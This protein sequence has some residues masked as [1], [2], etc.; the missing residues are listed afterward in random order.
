MKFT[1]KIL[2]AKLVLSNKE[3]QGISYVDVGKL[4][5]EKLQT[6]FSEDKFF[7]IKARER[8][9]EIF[10]RSRITHE[11][12]G[13]YLALK[14][15]GILFEPELKMNFIEFI[16][17]NTRDSVLILKWPGEIEANRIYFL[18]KANG[19]PVGLENINYRIV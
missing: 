13:S 3:L 6:E 11:S 17:S 18:S 1:D 9:V 15:L 16:L 4:F 5:S 7:A 12:L 10:N 8:L 2:N 19:I 14:N